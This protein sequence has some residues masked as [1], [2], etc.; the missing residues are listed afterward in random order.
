M[1]NEPVTQNFK[2][3]YLKQLAWVWNKKGSNIKKKRGGEIFL[4]LYK[5]GVFSSI[6]IILPP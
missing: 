5:V 4:L 3:K 6:P 1:L 2:T